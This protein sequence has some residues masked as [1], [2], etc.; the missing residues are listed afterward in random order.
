MAA[1]KALREKAKSLNIPAK[2]I[3][4]ADRDELEALIEKASD[5]GSPRKKNVAKK[6]VRKAVRKSTVAKKSAPAR[7][8][9]SGTA[10]RQTTRKAASNGNSG[11]VAKGGRNTLDGVDFSD[12]EDWNPRPGSAPDRIIKLLRK[13][14]GNRDKVYDALLPDIGDFVKNKKSNGEAWLKGDG[15][16]SRK[17]MLKYRIS[18]TAWQFAV[19][20]GQHEVADNRVDYGTGG[21]GEGIWK[22]AKARKAPASRPRG[23]KSPARKATRKAATKPQAKRGGKRRTTRRK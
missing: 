21:T 8:Q 22:P 18:R 19:Q 16:G 10:K 3:R 13:F 5:N 20:T 9:K 7:S 11:Y 15:P 17:G 23:G 4:T 14:R 12:H 2:Q 6:A 1:L